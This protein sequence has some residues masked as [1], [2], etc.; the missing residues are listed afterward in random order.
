MGG[1]F[2]TMRI[3]GLA[4]GMDIDSMVKQLM[5]AQRVPLTKL[6]QKKTQAEW[7]RADYTTMY[8][9][10]KD[11]KT[12][13]ADYKLSKTVNA[14]KAA[15]TNEAVATATANGAA[16]TVNHTL[17][18]AKLAE[19]ANITSGALGSA[20]D[21]T[22]L[23][24]QFAGNAS[25]PASDF[26]LKINGKDVTVKVGESINQMVSNI[27]NSG[28]GVKAVYDSNTDRIFISTNTTGAAAEINFT[29]TDATGQ[30]FLKDVLKMPTNPDSSLKL[31]SAG[32]DAEFTLDGVAL[33][34]SKNTFTIA[35]V[36]YTLKSAN[37]TTPLTTTVAVSVDIDKIVENV[38]KF[39]DSYNKLL[40]Q[41]Y[42]ELTESK[43][44]DFTPLTS[45]QKEAMSDEEIKQWE[46]K[47]KSGALRSDET[48]RQLVNSMRSNIYAAVQGIS[49]EYDQL[50]EIGITS[51]SYLENGKLYVNE[52]KLR[53]VLAEDPE[54]VNKL[55]AADGADS[56]HQGLARRLESTLDAAM[57]AIDKKAGVAKGAADTESVL[58][59]ELKEYNKRITALQTRLTDMETRYYK[60]FTAMERILQNLNS[61]SN[62]LSQQLGS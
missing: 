1:I 48:L 23:A 7:K 55:F 56:S 54:A 36:T 41:S 33:T 18:V 19:G 62:W 9:S 25:L 8:N 58:A 13:V 6:Q 38:N 61:K 46:E 20:A 49:G 16:A 52:T 3:S 40:A 28:A 45:E 2:M 57:K 37:S 27:N 43:Y 60:Q 34:Q 11:F 53:Q 14:Q 12:L 26:T 15:S 44:R 17:A 22:S 39:V 42:S 50:S 47:A 29:G 24:T 51:G 31:V 5:D 59:K 35:D 32:Q 4:S 10:I 30:A 21:K